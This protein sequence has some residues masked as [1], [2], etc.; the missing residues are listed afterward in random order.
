MRWVRL[1]AQPFRASALDLSTPSG[2]ALERFRRIG[3]TS[4]ASVVARSIAFATGFITVPLTLHYLGP[5]RYG[6]WATLSSVIALAGF[7]DLGLGNG[8]LNALAAAHGRDDRETAARQSSTAVVVLAGI[9]AALG[10]AFA[11]VYGRVDW[12]GVFNVASPAAVAESGPA[13]AALVTCLLVGLPLGIVARIRQGYQEGYKTSLY[14]AAASVLGLGLVLWAIQSRA[15]LVWLVVAMAGAPVAAS[16]VHALV[17]FGRDRPWLRVRLGGYDRGTAGTLLRYGLMFFALQGAAALMYALD[18]LIVTQIRGP[19]AVAQYSVAFKLFSVSLL[20]ADV[21]LVPL[22]PAY[23]EAIARGDHSWVRQTLRRSM[24][25]T[26]AAAL[27]LAT[28]LVVFG[29]AVIALW[30]GP[31]MIASGSLLLGLAA[32]TVV[33]AVGTSAAMYLNAANR[34]GVQLA[35]AAVMIP[36]SLA[37]KV[38]LVRS[39]G[40]A[41]VPWGLVIAY[42]AFVA[43]PLVVLALRGRLRPR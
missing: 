21:A 28:L 4:A 14:D 27:V 9:A 1:A 5:E 36:A 38:A 19:E 35:C 30:V 25:V 3:L 16:L 2:R 7:A 22:W 31:E 18:N 42:V 24:A 32:W 43:V 26:A 33:A 17:L 8:L 29:N 12:A 23:G 15:S 20:L 39:L 6:M 13:T 34:I 40:S 41:G 10:V 11:L 37:L